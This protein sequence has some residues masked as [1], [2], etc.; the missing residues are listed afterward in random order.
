MHACQE[1]RAPSFTT[2]GLFFSVPV[3]RWHLADTTPDMDGAKVIDAF[4]KAF[5]AWVP[6]MGPMSFASTDDKSKAHI[7]IN[8]AHQGDADLPEPF[9]SDSVLAY[10]YFPVNNYSEMWFDESE[11]WGEMHSNTKINLF[12]VAVH[13]L[14]HCLGL[15]HSTRNGDIMEAIYEPS[16]TVRITSDSEDGIVHLYTD[17][18]KTLGWVPP[19]EPPDNGGS[20]GCMVPIVIGGGVSLLGYLAYLN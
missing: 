4:R 9:G 19:V 20:K 15:D 13:E 3:I 16:N 6:Y 18:W 12:K 8:F 2:H 10:A 5:D 17:Y 11:N 1:C 14:G 7:V